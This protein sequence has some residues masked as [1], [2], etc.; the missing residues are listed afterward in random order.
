MTAPLVKESPSRTC[1]AVQEAVVDASRGASRSGKPAVSVIVPV[2]FAEKCLPEL[3][4]RVRT[5]LEEYNVTFELIL[6]DDDSPDK[7]WEIICGLCASDSRITGIRF[8][9]NFGQHY[10]ITAGLDRSRGDWVVVM[11]CDLQDSPE[12][13]P[14]LYDKALEG[15]DI[16][17]ARRAERKDSLLKRIPSHLFYKLFSYLT[18]LEY[19]GAVGNFRIM[20][21]QVVMNLT[22]MRENLRFFGA[23]VQWLGFKKAAVDVRHS[24]RFAGQS[25]YTIGKL[26]ALAT[27]T[28]IAFSDKPLRLAVRFG[29]LMAATSFCLGF[30]IVVRA[31]AYG[32]PVLGWSSLIASLYFLGG[33]NITLLGVVGTYVGK[34]FSESKK[35]PLYVIR[36]VAGSFDAAEH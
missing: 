1:Q 28:I 19:D 24:S 25:T 20:S 18:D 33:L 14:E 16:V 21:R 13:I 10:G 5:V 9:R 26:I 15:Y 4:S 34:T 36:D 7:S 12:A 31:L 3:W 30:A 8:S 22:K 17:V 29:F 2:Y 11:D 6:V 27:E 32:T 35:R 23:Q